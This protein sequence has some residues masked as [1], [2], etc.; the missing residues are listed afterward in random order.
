MLIVPAEGKCPR[1]GT[2]D[3]NFLTPLSNSRLPNL[4]LEM[5]KLS[6]AVSRFMTIIIM[7][8]S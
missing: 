2:I 1:F 4:Y 5:T 8:M 7:R 3:C 6:R